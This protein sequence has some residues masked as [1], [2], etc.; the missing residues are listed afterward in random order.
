MSV[1]FAPPCTFK[2]WNWIKLNIIFWN[3][4][5]CETFNSL[6]SQCV[7]R[8]LCFLYTILNY[9]IVKSGLQVGILFLDNGQTETEKKYEKIC[10]KKSLL[11]VKWVFYPI[12]GTEGLLMSFGIEDMNYANCKNYLL[13]VNSKL[14]CVYVQSPSVN[15]ASL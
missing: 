11:K 6:S 2:I 7:L 5:E 8:N 12:L 13:H 15:G 9:Y 3:I 1:S 10:N 14:M 4:R